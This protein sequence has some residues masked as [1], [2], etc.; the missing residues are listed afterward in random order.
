LLL[1]GPAVMVFA[2]PA[3]TPGLIYERSE[4]LRG[5][6]WRLW[7]GHWVHF[8]GAHLF[9]N[10]AV[11]V[12]AG[13]WAERLAPS[14]FRVLCF[15][16]AGVIGAA[17]LLLDPALAHYGG[18]SALAAAALAFLALAQLSARTDGRWF[19]RGVLLLLGLKIAAEMLLGRSLLADFEETGIRGVPLAHLAGILSAVVVHLARR[20]QI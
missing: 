9:W 20:R 13:G 8:G 14:A 3:L 19:W 12:P 2:F 17:M 1:V 18:L 6:I 7:T 15:L 16:S 11:L 10:L 5:Q 4:I